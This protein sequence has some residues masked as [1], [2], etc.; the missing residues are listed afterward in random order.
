MALLQ[1]ENAAYT[2][3]VSQA[4]GTVGSTNPALLLTPD[5]VGFILIPILMA[6]IG[7]AI[8]ALIA[9]VYNLLADKI[10]GL[11]YETK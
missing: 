7:F 1:G 11:E 3:A 9:F 6:I 8:G 2:E 10:G 4:G 5:I